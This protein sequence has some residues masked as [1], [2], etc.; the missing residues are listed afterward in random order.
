ML[1]LLI[2]KDDFVYWNQFS[3]YFIILVMRF[4]YEDLEVWQLSK[5]L[6]KLVYK[7]TAHFPKD[8]VFNLTSQVRRASTPCCLNISEGSGRNA[9]KDFSRFIRISIGSL[10]E[11]DTCLKITID[12][13]YMKNEIYEEEFDELIAELYF[14]LIKLDKALQSKAYISN[15]YNN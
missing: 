12:L 9:R 14:K 11:V 6:V 2:E 15:N 5:R 1:E 7:V 10:L 3:S 8:E 13:E 4:K